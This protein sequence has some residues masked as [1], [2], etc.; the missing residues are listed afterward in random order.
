LA[1]GAV[2]GGFVGSVAGG[3]VFGDAAGGDRSKEK[4][5][6]GSVVALWAEGERAARVEGDDDQNPGEPPE[7]EERMEEAAGHEDEDIAPKR[8]EQIME[9]EFTL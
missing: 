9:T 8:G 4:R 3:I 6:G 1:D 2:G 7:G 5:N